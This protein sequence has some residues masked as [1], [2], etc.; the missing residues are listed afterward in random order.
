MSLNAMILLNVLP[1]AAVV[2]GLAA[3][4]TRP[5]VLERRERKIAPVAR[6]QELRRAA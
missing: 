5:F 2:G 4:L 6:P 3:V 1:D